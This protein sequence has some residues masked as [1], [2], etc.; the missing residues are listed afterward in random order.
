[1]SEIS[2]LQV[3]PVTSAFEQMRFKLGENGMALLGG[4]LQTWAE[5]NRRRIE[6]PLRDALLKGDTRLPEGTLL[7][8]MGTY[9]FSTEAIKGVSEKGILSGELIGISEDSETHGCADFFRAPTDTTVGDYF[10]WAKEPR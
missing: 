6:S 1:M 4:Q 3:E 2:H 9:V 7:H 10:A 8:G 5:L